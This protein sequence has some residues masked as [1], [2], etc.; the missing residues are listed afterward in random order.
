MLRRAFWVLLA[1]CA[2]ALAQPY[3]NYRGI[4]NVASYMAPGLP[5]G[6]LPQGGM[7]AIFGRNLGPAAGAQATTFPLQTTLSGVSITVTQQSTTVNALPVYVGPGQVNAI[8]PSNAPLGRASVWVTVNGVTSNPSPVNVVASSFGSFAVNSGGFGPGIIQNYTAAGAAI[9]STQATAQPGGVEVLW[10]TGLGPVAVDSV[11]P[12]PGNLPVKVEVFVGGQSAAILYSGRTSCCSGID[13]INFTVPAGAAAGCYVPV[14]VRV[15]GSVVSNTVTMAIDPNGAPCSDA[16]NPLGAILRGGGRFG[17]ALLSHE[18]LQI[19]ASGAAQSFTVDEAGLSLRQETGGAWAFN[20]YVSL[21]PLG[22][23]TA[24]G[25]AGDYPSLNDVPGIAPSIK[26]L[27]GGTLI[28]LAAPPGTVS[29]PQSATSPVFYSALLATSLNVPG[30]P[31]SFLTSGTASTLSGAGGADV[32][33]FQASITAGPSFTWTNEAAVT[34]V[35]RANGFT[36]TWSNPPPGAAAVSIIG[37]NVDQ[38]N[39]AS[40]GF[41]CL[42]T[43]SAGSFTVP[44]VALGN[45]PA[46]PSGAVANQ[47]WISVGA[48]LSGSSVSFSAS[49]LDR[50]MAVFASSSRQAVV[51]Q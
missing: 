21:P 33:P 36:V 35:T 8:I 40:G 1:F 17:A 9:N 16:A 39:N 41:Q 43:P 11:A 2:T 27:D 23:C 6:S 31:T 4:V 45:V 12:T 20:P 24:Y 3:I 44:A 49:G 22:T 19:N 42:A 37:Y 50:G 28:S 14:V 26:D 32:G 29:M 47:G 30:V 38:A 15:G 5:A 46:T 34:S 48:A 51:Y 25:I 10:G 7:V 18:N 13:Q